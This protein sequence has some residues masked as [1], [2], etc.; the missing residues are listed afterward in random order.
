[1]SE[2]MLTRREL[3]ERLHVTVKTVGKMMARG[4]LRVHR[5]GAD[6]RFLWS[7]VVE[8][9]R[10]VSMSDAQAVGKVMRRVS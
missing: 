1:M 10:E 8:D 6:P 2:R 4:E 7:E 9:T 5:V 3:A